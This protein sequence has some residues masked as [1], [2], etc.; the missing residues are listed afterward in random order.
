MNRHTYD[1][2]RVIAGLGLVLLVICA[3]NYY[4][5]FRIFGKYNKQIFVTCVVVVIGCIS[6]FRR[7]KQDIENAGSQKHDL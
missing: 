6:Y 3:A 1:R 2:T 5:D 4:F 7:T